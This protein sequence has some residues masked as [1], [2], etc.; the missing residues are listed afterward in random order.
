MP[1]QNKRVEE[2]SVESRHHV[3]ETVFT[4]GVASTTQ[5]GKLLSEP[6]FALSPVFLQRRL[7]QLV[8][9]TLTGSSPRRIT[10]YH[11]LE[12]LKIC[13]SR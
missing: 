12:Y 7:C 1:E 5:H 8:A 4:K 10:P 11:T 3:D 9:M 2:F 6:E 13:V